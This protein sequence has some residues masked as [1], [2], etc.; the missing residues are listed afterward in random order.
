MSWRIAQM[1]RFERLALNALRNQSTFVALNKRDLKAIGQIQRSPQLSDVLESIQRWCSKPPKGFEKFFKDKPSGKARKQSSSKEAPKEG[2]KAQPK[3]K[4]SNS[5]P[6]FFKLGSRGG[7]KGTGGGFG[8]MPD[9]EKQGLASMVGLGAVGILAFL[10]LNQ[11]KYRCF[12][13][14][15]SS[16]YFSVLF[17]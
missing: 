13:Y 8:Q 16:F 3:P 2:R 4:E 11:M 15:C 12:V 1:R 5:T 14:I 9:S 7:G 17:Y 10:Y 6:D